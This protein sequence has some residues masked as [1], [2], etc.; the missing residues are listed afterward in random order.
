MTAP[1]PAVLMGEEIAR[2]HPSIVEEI[3]RAMI[4]AQLTIED[5]GPCHEPMLERIV[6]HLRS[7]LY[8]LDACVIEPRAALGEAAE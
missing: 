5:V 2:L 7:A 8:Q 3:E 1:A 4:V 6:K